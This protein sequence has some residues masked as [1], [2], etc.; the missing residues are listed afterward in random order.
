MFGGE[1]SFGGIVAMFFVVYII[2]G[3]VFYSALEN[4]SVGDAIYFTVNTFLSIGYNS[5]GMTG[6]MERFFTGFFVLLGAGFAGSAIGI[7]LG[8][9]SDSQ[10]EDLERYRNSKAYKDR[11]GD[12]TFS[13]PAW[14]KAHALRKLCISC[15]EIFIVM[16]IGT[17]IMGLVEVWSFP[18]AFYW[19]AV[20][21][22]TTGYGDL[23]PTGD[24]TKWFTTVYS[25]IGVVTLAR[26]L[27]FIARFPLIQRRLGRDKE[28]LRR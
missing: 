27:S 1:L 9:E 12:A 5:M 16:A 22:T 19:A 8:Q 25:V 24:S 10:E 4:F 28:V 23:V 20:T 14:E 21:I 3:V 26:A 2:I 7:L 15:L 6:K 18:E 13:R 11:G 17:I